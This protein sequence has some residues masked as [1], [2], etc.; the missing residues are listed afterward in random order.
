ME[1][2]DEINIQF[3]VESQTIFLE[4]AF[5]FSYHKKKKIHDGGLGLTAGR[6][7]GESDSFCRSY[8]LF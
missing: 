3:V 1:I 4:F 8:I 7:P 6:S 2:K 5:N